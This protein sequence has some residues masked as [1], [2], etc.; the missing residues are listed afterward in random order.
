MLSDKMTQLWNKF[1]KQKKMEIEEKF[2]H[3]NQYYQSIKQGAE[4]ALSWKRGKHT[5]A[6]VRTIAK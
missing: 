1:S 5:G 3:E 6:R 4:E 2:T